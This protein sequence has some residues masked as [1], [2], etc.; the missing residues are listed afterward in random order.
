LRAQ[1]ERQIGREFHARFGTEITAQGVLRDEASRKQRHV[2]VF[3]DR[4]GRTLQM[5]VVHKRRVLWKQ[6]DFV[7]RKILQHF[8]TELVM[9]GLRSSEIAA[10]VHQNR[11]IAE[12]R[13]RGIAIIGLSRAFIGDRDAE[14]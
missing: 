11:A 12:L 13:R 10:A 1:H 3:A 6:D 4:I 5:L 9:H 7:A 14:V 2:R 8:Q